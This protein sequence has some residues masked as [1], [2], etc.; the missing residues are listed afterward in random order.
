MPRVIDFDKGNETDWNEVRLPE[1]HYGDKEIRNEELDAMVE[2]FKD[3]VGGFEPQFSTYGKK[4]DHGDRQRLFDAAHAWLS[5]NA[6]GPWRW[7]ESWGNHGHHL[8]VH[9]YVERVPDQMAFASAHEAMFSY[10]PAEDLARLAVERG[11]LP[12]LTSMESFYVWTK[13]HV[14]FEFLKA[15]DLGERGMRVTFSHDGLEQAFKARWADSFVQREVEGRSVYEGSEKGL[16]W[17]QSPSI[18]LTNHSPIGN[19]SGGNGPDGY[20]WSVVARFEDVADALARD[21][22]HAFKAGEDG[23]TFWAESY[24][25]PP[26]RDIPADFRAYIEGERDDYEAPHL[27]ESLKAFREQPCPAPGR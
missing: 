25:F 19:I 11:A 3:L 8:D 17:D 6:T 23:R 9:V 26:K 15:E 1:P 22:G 14:G 24:P 7:S 2:A 4:I 21:W 12:P 10:R 27:P 13:E 20:K 18:W 5:E 16:R